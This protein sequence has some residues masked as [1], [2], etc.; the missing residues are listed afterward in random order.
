[1]DPSLLEKLPLDNLLKILLYLDIDKVK[2]LEA[3]S[4]TIRNNMFKSRFWLN[5]YMQDFPNDYEAYRDY[6]EDLD[7]R[8]DERLELMSQNPS[9]EITKWKRMYEAAEYA[10]NRGIR[11]IDFLFSDW[12]PDGEIQN[13]QMTIRHWLSDDEVVATTT[14]K[15]LFIYNIEQKRI[16]VE[17]NWKDI[18]WASIQFKGSKVAW[19]TNTIHI[20]DVRDQNYHV[21]KKIIYLNGYGKFNNDGDGIATDFAL[22]ATGNIIYYISKYGRGFIKFGPNTT[23]VAEGI[24]KLYTTSNDDYILLHAGN[25]VIRMTLNEL[26][27]DKEWEYSLKSTSKDF[28]R[29]VSSDGEKFLTLNRESRRSDYPDLRMVFSLRNFEKPLWSKYFERSPWSDAV[30]DVKFSNDGNT[31]VWLNYTEEEIG[32]VKIDAMNKELS[33]GDFENFPFS[34]YI[35]PSAKFILFQSTEGIII[36]KKTKASLVSTQCIRCKSKARYV[37]H[38]DPTKLY[39]S[40]QCKLK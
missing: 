22:T 27:V 9:N 13:V 30:V 36:W 32:A 33:F 39:C 5:R 2:E 38:T 15:Q 3:L 4:S 23:T 18:D 35:S 29:G 26:H 8:Y 24:T 6:Q 10:R 37:Q 20:K 11:A 16:T 12:L 40:V 31:L 19:K 25:S 28:L 21:E 1:M 17:L 34:T 7:T 14:E